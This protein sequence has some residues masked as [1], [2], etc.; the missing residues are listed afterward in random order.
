MAPLAGLADLYGQSAAGRTGAG[1]LESQGTVADAAHGQWGDSAGYPQYAAP[2]PSTGQNP[3]APDWAMI[4]DA[5]PLAPVGDHPHDQTPISAA[6]PYPRTVPEDSELRNPD[7]QWRAQVESVDLHGVYLGGIYQNEAPGGRETP[8]S[9]DQRYQVSDGST[10][11]EQVPGQIRGAGTGNDVAQGF[12]TANRFGFDAGH[13]QYLAQTD[14]VP[15]NFQ[16]L[17]AGE[18]PFIVPAAGV[19]ATFSG[20]DSPY[21]AL[22]DTTQDM[23]Q[24]T[25][26]AA[27]ESYPTA[28]QA[29]PDPVVL[30]AGPAS[31]E[32]PVI[33]GWF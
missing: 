18:R 28:Y 4:G 19:Q 11:L 13:L 22:G 29:P 20:P 2:Y 24:G 32:A 30:P 6:A 15:G 31:G 7:A 27:V 25:D 21:G 5:P 14:P 26:G 3:Y 33:G 17:E 8:T 10:E 23:H 16:W 1:A 9:W 12:G